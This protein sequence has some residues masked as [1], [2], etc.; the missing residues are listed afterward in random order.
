MTK[1]DSY[2]LSSLCTVDWQVAHQSIGNS[3]STLIGLLVS[4]WIQTCRLNRW[5][6]EGAPSFGKKNSERTGKSDALFCDGQSI[7]GI[8]EVEGSRYQ[9]TISKIEKHFRSKAEDLKKLRFAVLLLYPESPKG[10]G[11]NRT[12]PDLSSSTFVEQVKQLSQKYPTKTILLIL[13]YKQFERVLTGIRSKNEYYSGSVSKVSA[14]L[15]RKGELI[16][17]LT[18]FHSEN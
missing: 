4:W 5:A 11:A 18:L 2:F 9:Y 17:S 3:H 8:L 1:N 6:V 12:F 13:L 7:V 14:Q 16:G 10:K 15:F